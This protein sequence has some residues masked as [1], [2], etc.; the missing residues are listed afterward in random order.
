MIIEENQDLK[1]CF[2]HRPLS[3]FH[4][5]VVLVLQ[6]T[7][8]HKTNTMYFSHRNTRAMHLK[9]CYIA[10]ALAVVCTLAFMI[11]IQ[12]EGAASPHLL[13]SSR[14]LPPEMTHHGL[15]Y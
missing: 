14:T 7:Q 12:D 10:T 8:H 13:L 5:R 11:V 1:Y 3:G 15:L 4:I 6:G 2:L 9:R